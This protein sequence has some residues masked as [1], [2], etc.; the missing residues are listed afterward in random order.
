[1][2]E[3]CPIDSN[4]LS[5][6]NRTAIRNGLGETF[7]IRFV[8]TFAGY[9]A[10]VLEPE[11]TE[12]VS[13]DPARVPK[14]QLIQ[15]YAHGRYDQYVSLAISK[16]PEGTDFHPLKIPVGEYGIEA[17]SALS[18][19]SARLVSHLAEI[20]T[21]PLNAHERM[22]VGH[23]TYYGT[24]QKY[25]ERS[26]LTNQQQG[27]AFTIHTLAA[28]TS[29]KVEGYEA[30]PDLLRGV[31]E[32]YT[33]ETLTKMVGSLA[34]TPLVEEGFFIEHPLT[35]ALTVSPEMTEYANA[36]RKRHRAKARE[37]RKKYQELWYDVTHGE[38]DPDDVD[39]DELR[40]LHQVGALG[41]SCPAADRG[42]SVTMTVRSLSKIVD[43][44]I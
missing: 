6:A 8:N 25:G 5:A 29:Q 26:F 39:Q 12:L 9:E 30:F 7:D 22:L 13:Y 38:I 23:H 1:M 3:R 44:L 41:L 2:V 4:D 43:T 28:L 19:A 11:H 33:T 35:P 21:R 36:T 17:A 42:G 16:A 18:T 40:R 37:S 15:E 34:V 10:D 20:S 14:D 27:V 24:T 32:C 31:A